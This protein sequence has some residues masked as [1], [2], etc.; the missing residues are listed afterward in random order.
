MNIRGGIGGS[1]GG[2]GVL[3]VSGGQYY[4]GGMFQV[5]IAPVIAQSV[6]LQPIPVR[7]S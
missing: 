4:I 1:G 7:L 5:S 2:G 6:N 3:G